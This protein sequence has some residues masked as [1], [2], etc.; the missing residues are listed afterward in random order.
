MQS[1]QSTLNEYLGS[2]QSTLGLVLAFFGVG[3][4]VALMVVAPQMLGEAG[5]AHWKSWILGIGLWA[6]ISVGLGL[7]LRRTEASLPMIVMACLWLLPAVGLG[8]MAKFQ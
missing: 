3:T 6:V 1:E 4:L 8:L 2:R 7:R 5:G